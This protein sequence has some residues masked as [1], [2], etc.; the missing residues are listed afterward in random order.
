MTGRDIYEGY[1]QTECILV[2]G[3][4]ADSPLRPGSMG[5]RAPG[6]P[7]HVIDDTGAICPV[8]VEGDIAIK[9][10][11]IGSSQF[12]GIFDG[13]IGSDGV[14]DRKS[15]RG[16][17]GEEWYPT[18]DRAT[19][20]DAGYFWFVGRSDDVISSAG[21][22]IG[23]FEVESTLKEH[24]AVVES[25]AVSSPDIE[26]GEVVKAFIVLTGESA[27]IDRQQLKKE[28]QDFCKKRAA[29]Y[30]YPRKIQ[31]VTADWLARYKTTSGK[32]QRKRLKELE[33]QSTKAK[34]K[35]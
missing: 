8:G 9:I 32:T 24:Q 25:A 31:F 18:G 30:K 14:L 13:Y 23:P 7:L 19:V 29:P 16:A 27:D 28:L 21:Y 22:R 26:R 4:F 15:I 3:N 11:N 33:W 20:D 10:E 6:V 12:F 1:G 35:L 17:S 34:A 5:R 2:C